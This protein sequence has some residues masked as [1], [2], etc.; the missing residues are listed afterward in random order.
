M[1]NQ[2]AQP[3]P[4]FASFVDMLLETLAKL[5][6]AKADGADVQATR[7]NFARALFNAF[8]PRDV[9]EA[10]VAADAAAAHCAAMDLFARAAPSS[11]SDES[12]LSLR[13]KALA[14]SRSFHA[15]LRMLD[16]RRAP[17]A[18][19]PA[20]LRRPDAR[21]ATARPELPPETPAR[22]PAAPAE[23]PDWPATAVQPQRR[24][25]FRDTTALTTT[26]LDLAA[27]LAVAACA[28]G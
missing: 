1:I 5:V 13:G 15:A 22:R 20:D 7:R 17:V 27:Q 14:A 9:L 21:A 6:P 16:K 2:A 19:P 28:T 12:V 18:K 8:K 4:L 3:E 23:L 26:N 10:M 24:A 11:M 25:A